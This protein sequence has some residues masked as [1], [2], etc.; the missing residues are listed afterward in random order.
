ME[1]IYE[2]KRIILNFKASEREEQVLAMMTILTGHSR[3][4]MLRVLIR[5]GAER[6]GLHVFGTE[7][8]KVAPDGN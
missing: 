7:K 8:E 2:K 6:R 4:E 3:S 5:E 1:K